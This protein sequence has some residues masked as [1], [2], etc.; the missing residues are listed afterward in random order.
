MKA[1]KK[2]ELL[3]RL[4]KDGVNQK[5]KNS[6]GAILQKVVILNPE[7]LSYTLKDYVFKEPQRHWPGYS[8][9][10]RQS[11]ESVLSRKLNPSQ[12]TAGTSCSESP[13]C[14][15]R[16]AVSSSQKQLLDS[17]FI[18]P[19]MNKN[20]RISHLT[21][22]VPPTLNGRL[23]PTSEKSAANFLL[24]ACSFYHSCPSTAAASIPPF[25]KSSLDCK[26]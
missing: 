3:A 22:R 16:D 15:N 12:N 10:D 11:L 7:G 6:L 20:P 24:T 1:Y 23:N 4:Q 14:S 8:D 2:P 21:N 26:F 5:E 13:L 25:L 19:L 17:Y 9:I 18:G